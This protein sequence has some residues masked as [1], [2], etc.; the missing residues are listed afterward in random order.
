VRLYDPDLDPPEAMAF[1]PYPEIKLTW[2]KRNPLRLSQL[3]SSPRGEVCRRDAEGA[4]ANRPC[5]ERDMR[6]FAPFK[7]PLTRTRKVRFEDERRNGRLVPRVEAERVFWLA[8]APYTEEQLHCQ[9]LMGDWIAEYR[10]D[11]GEETDEYPIFGLCRRN[12]LPGFYGV[13]EIFHE[14]PVEPPYEFP[15]ANSILGPFPPP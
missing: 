13:S 6:V 14:T 7:V 1:D 8:V 3:V 15:P 11:G 4:V 5:F 9:Q 12:F 2:T 10:A